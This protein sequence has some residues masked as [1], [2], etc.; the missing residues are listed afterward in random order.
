[1]DEAVAVKTEVLELMR[2]ELAARITAETEAQAIAARQQAVMEA[3]QVRRE[4]DAAPAAQ[5]QTRPT[6]LSSHRIVDARPAHGI[7]DLWRAAEKPSISRPVDNRPPI[8][9]GTLCALAGEGVSITAA[10][11]QSLGI[12][13]VERPKESK[14]GTYWAAGDVP[15]IFSTLAVHF[16]KLA[17]QDSALAA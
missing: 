1:M 7:D 4:E 3:A 11:L 14:S 13:P 10:F 6:Q 8:T 2:A 12:H 16:A 5:E 17:K 9:T 15:L